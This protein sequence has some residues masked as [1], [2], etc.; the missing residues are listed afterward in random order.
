MNQQNNTLHLGELEGPLLIFGGVYSNL[1]ALDAMMEKAKELQIPP[2]NIICT[3]D[4]VGYCANPEEVVQKVRNWGIHVIAGNVELQLR[5]GEEDCGCDFSEGGTCDLYS[6]Q[7]YPF[8]QSK[9]SKAS[10]DWMKGLPEFIHFSYAGKKVVV[11]HGSL[12]HTSEFIFKSTDWQIKANNFDCSGADV[13]LAGHCGLPFS[14]S[15]SNKHWLNAGVIGM[16]ANDATTRVW[17]MTLSNQ[18]GF[19]FKHKE[20]NYQYALA[21]EQIRKA[22]LPEAYAET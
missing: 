17:F 3:G 21:A 9:I 18:N 13:V 11:L 15:R 19:D 20:L 8:A 22:K 2:S 1:Q 10:I 12:Q 16:P 5:E 7:W 14:D 4:V 6:K